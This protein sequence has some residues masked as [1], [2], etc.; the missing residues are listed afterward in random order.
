M[1]LV[2]LVAPMLLSVN[3][4]PECWL[5]HPGDFPASESALVARFFCEPGLDAPDAWGIL[6]VTLIRGPRAPLLIF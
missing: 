4:V 2:R 1:P 3:S 6:I 5:C